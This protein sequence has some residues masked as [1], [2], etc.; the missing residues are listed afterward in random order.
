[1]LFMIPIFICIPCQV[2]EWREKKNHI[3]VSLNQKD[4]LTLAQAQGTYHVLASYQHS[5][6]AIYLF[7]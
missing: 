1:M 6:Y 4:V 7:V 5:L 3:D 2:E